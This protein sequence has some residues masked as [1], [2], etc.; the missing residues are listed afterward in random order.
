MLVSNSIN[1]IVKL[2]WEGETPA[3]WERVCDLGLGLQLHSLSTSQNWG[4]QCIVAT[5]DGLLLR[6][7]GGASARAFHYCFTEVKYVNILHQLPLFIGIS[8]AYF[9]SD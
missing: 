1:K 4:V 7:A 6:I 3:G 8:L 5:R 9:T 2:K